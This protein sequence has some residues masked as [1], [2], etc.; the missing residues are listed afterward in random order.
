MSPMRPALSLVLLVAALVALLSAC[1]R[2]DDKVLFA[3]DE[4]AKIACTDTC[5]GRGQCGTLPDKQRVV[6]ANE[7][8]PSVSIHDRL[9]FEGAAVTVV[10]SNPRQLIAASDGQQLIG[11]ATPF[12]HTF[13][14][15]NGE[16]RTAWVSEW[17][18][19]RP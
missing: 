12:H 17:C 1:R 9:F 16:G 2:G 18:L 4:Q 10:E 5:A 6:L 13:N 8:G 19:A 11:K 14:R 3:V 7:G 15:V